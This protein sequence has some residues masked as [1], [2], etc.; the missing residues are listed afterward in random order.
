MTI[1]Q[2][3]AIRVQSSLSDDEL[4]LIVAKSHV[5][6]AS[7]LG[8]ADLLALAR[9]WLNNLA[10]ESRDALC[11]SATKELIESKRLDDAEAIAVLTD[12][13]AAAHGA[14]VA[15]A[16]AVLLFRWGLERICDDS[17]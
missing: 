3:D 4:L 13:L 17:I 10:K 6:A 11:G 1:E 2:L 8:P 5:A 14:P 9:V 12:V 7:G 16:A 15:S